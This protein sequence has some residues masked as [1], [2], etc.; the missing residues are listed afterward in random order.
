MKSYLQALAEVDLPKTHLTHQKPTRLSWIQRLR[1]WFWTPRKSALLRAASELYQINLQLHSL[2][3]RE[4]VRQS[5]QE[6]RALMTE[7]ERTQQ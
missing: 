1:R 7:I 3:R 5:V 4:A 6:A 2:E